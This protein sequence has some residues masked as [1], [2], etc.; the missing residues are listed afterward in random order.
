MY[1]KF[2]SEHAIV[3]QKDIPLM[4]MFYVEDDELEKFLEGL[5]EI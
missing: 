1:T 2:E 5:S 3:F 4:D